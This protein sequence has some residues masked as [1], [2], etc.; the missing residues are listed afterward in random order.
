[1]VGTRMHVRL[2]D[3]ALEAKRR[4]LEA[5]RDAPKTQG[6]IEAKT[7]PRPAEI[8]AKYFRGEGRDR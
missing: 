2:A 3:P 4:T 5:V 8:C 7:L 6:R 1:M